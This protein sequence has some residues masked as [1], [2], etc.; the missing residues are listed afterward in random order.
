MRLLAILFVVMSVVTALPAHSQQNNNW[1][2]G[3][4]AGLN[5]TS[6][7]GQPTPSLLSNSAMIADEGSAAISDSNG[8]LQFYSNGVKVFNKQHQVMLNGDGLL[9]D[10]SACQSSI[11]VPVP[12]NEKKFYLFTTDAV[13]NDF[14]NGY[15]YSIIDMDGDNGNGE[16]V[17]KNTLLWASCTERLTAVRHGNG[18]DIWLI[19]N[20]NNSNIFRSWLISCNGLNPTPVTSAVGIVMNQHVVT[21]TGFMKVSPNGKYLCQTHF[22]LFDPD[23]VSNN[24]FQLFE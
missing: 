5:F 23:V 3:S 22:P 1:Y 14:E 11:I 7:P 13:E 10:I 9:G 15:R 4:F 12:G 20:D 21:N 16:V 19:T 2:F 18:I 24:F 17:E 8:N 6:N